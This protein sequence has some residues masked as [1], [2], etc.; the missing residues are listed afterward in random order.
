M[1]RFFVQDIAP[2]A[3]DVVITGEEA[4]HLNRVLRLGRGDLIE[5]WD[6]QGRSYTAQITQSDEAKSRARLLTP[7]LREREPRL[8]LTLAKAL[9]KGE[10][11]DFVLQKGTELGVHTFVPTICR[12]SVVRLGKEREIRRRQR[13]QRIVRE[14]AKQCG[15]TFVPVVTPVLGLEK[16]LQEYREKGSQIIFPY[17]GEEGRGL[18]EVLGNIFTQSGTGAG[19]LL[20]VGPEGGFTPEEVGLAAQY[21]AQIVS[22]GPRVLRSET[23]TLAAV[24]IIFY[25]AGDLGSVGGE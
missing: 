11:M 9:I 19:V 16:V 20:M 18:D 1:H 15:R 12:R 25:G 23:A 6:G 5:V 17:E 3:V 21:G 10:R 22:L 7:I 24:S 14:A 4:V 2:D 8:K 13:W